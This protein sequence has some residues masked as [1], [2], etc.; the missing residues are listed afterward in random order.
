MLLLDIIADRGMSDRLT[1]QLE[2]GNIRI[3]LKFNK[4]LPEAI[5]CLLYLEF[6]D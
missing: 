3:K 2:F 1:S 5:T 6:D 4:S